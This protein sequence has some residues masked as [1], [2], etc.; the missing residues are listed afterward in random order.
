[1]D[2]VIKTLLQQQFARMGFRKRGPVWERERE[3]VR[4]FLH[5][6]HA[7]YLPQFFVNVGVLLKVAD[8]GAKVKNPAD[9]HLDVRAGDLAP[10]LVHTEFGDA[11]SEDV[12]IPD[13]DRERIIR[14]VLEVYVEQF[15]AQYDN[16]EAIL[17]LARTRRP[18]RPNRSIVVWWPMLEY[19]GVQNRRPSDPDFDP[20]WVP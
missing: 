14:Q 19:A 3:E 5:I 15:F 9:C 13:A 11:I 7:R 17:R 18:E 6:Q 10:Q 1:M 12:S 2:D 8:P 16:E 4:Q 20:T